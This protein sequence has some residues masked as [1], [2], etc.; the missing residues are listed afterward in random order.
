MTLS[1]STSPM[2]SR[3]PQ[4]QLVW[5]RTDAW[6]GLIALER[7]WEGQGLRPSTFLV[8]VQR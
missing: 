8:S 7:A 1:W 5:R 6:V 3:A 4:R 2:T